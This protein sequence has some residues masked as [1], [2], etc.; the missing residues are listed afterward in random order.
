LC[1]LGAVIKRW[2]AATAVT[3]RHRYVVA[4]L[5]C[6]RRSVQALRSLDI[7]KRA[8]SQQRKL[9]RPSRGTTSRQLRRTGGGEWPL[10]KSLALG[11]ALRIDL[12]H[13]EPRKHSG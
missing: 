4:P 1:A 10:M 7:A 11:A 6:R 3:P 5:S 2:P 12:G 9:E 8:E 13:I